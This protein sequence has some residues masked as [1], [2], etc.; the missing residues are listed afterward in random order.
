MQRRC[1]PAL[2]FSHLTSPDCE[3]ALPARG[4]TDPA[5]SRGRVRRSRQAQDT[6]YFHQA[7]QRSWSSLVENTATV[8]EPETVYGLP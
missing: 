7:V 5:G 1:R 3:P 6:V 4:W 8:A 2:R